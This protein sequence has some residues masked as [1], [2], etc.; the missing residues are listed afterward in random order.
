MM[1]RDLRLVLDNHQ[2]G[3][4]KYRDKAKYAL[5]MLLHNCLSSWEDVRRNTPIR[6]LQVMD[7]KDVCYVRL[8]LEAWAVATDEDAIEIVLVVESERPSIEK[9]EVYSLGGPERANNETC[10]LLV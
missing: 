8:W 4:S 1:R 9:V 3:G 2:D 5:Q 10:L 7:L 6:R